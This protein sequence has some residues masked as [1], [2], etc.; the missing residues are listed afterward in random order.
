MTRHRLS[1]APA[2]HGRPEA[3]RC[4]DGG[5]FDPRQAPETPHDG[6]RPSI[7]VMGFTGRSTPNSITRARL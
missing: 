5:L 3:G 1:H 4:A 6:H 2:E 7:P